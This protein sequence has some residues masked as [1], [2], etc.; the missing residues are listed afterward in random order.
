M[1][2]ARGLRCKRF[3][4]VYTGFALLVNRVHGSEM[5]REWRPI[6]QAHYCCLY[7]R[8]GED[9][10]PVRI[11]AK[12]KAAADGFWTW[13]PYWN[14]L[15]FAKNYVHS[16]VTVITKYSGNQSDGCVSTQ[17]SAVIA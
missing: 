8:K 16:F 15:K 10:E 2:L 11:L 6:V 3:L 14:Y 7:F 4:E 13:R 5:S 9:G 12:E 17:N 1:G